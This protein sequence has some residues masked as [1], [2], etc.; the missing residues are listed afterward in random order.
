MAARRTNSANG[1]GQSDQ[2][3][4]PSRNYL[5][6]FVT[7]KFEG[8]DGEEKTNFTR[9]GVAFPHRNGG[10]YNIEIQTGISVSGKLVVLPPKD[11]E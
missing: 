4:A 7:E 1:R 11:E 8:R 5:G 10:G 3:S 6:V 2:A 9:V